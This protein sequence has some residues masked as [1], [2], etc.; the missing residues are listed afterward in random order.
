MLKSILITIILIIVNTI[1]EE[2]KA[3]LAPIN[4]YF[5]V[6]IMEKNILKNEAIIVDHKV[7]S[8]FFSLENIV[9]AKPAIE[10]DATPKSVTGIITNASI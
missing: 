1:K 4:P 10:L 5:L 8:V 6:K 9:P 3:I 2:V 7:H